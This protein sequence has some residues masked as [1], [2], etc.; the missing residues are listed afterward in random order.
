MHILWILLVYDSQEPDNF[1]KLEISPILYIRNSHEAEE[2]GAEKEVIYPNQK[3]EQDDVKSEWH[4][5]TVEIDSTVQRD[6]GTNN[7]S[8]LQIIVNIGSIG[9]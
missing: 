6:D 7:F 4:R 2:Q 3:H 8:L 5:A 9:L 1:D